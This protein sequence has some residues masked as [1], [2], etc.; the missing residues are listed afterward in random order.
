MQQP[1]AAITKLAVVVPHPVSRFRVLRFHGSHYRWADS[2]VKRIIEK[3]RL[4]L[5][6]FGAILRAGGAKVAKLQTFKVD[7]KLH[8]RAKIAAI[9]AGMKLEAWV[10][11]AIKAALGAGV[12]R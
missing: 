12:E 8:A 2:G 9:K 6:P 1:P 10:A 5:R 4:R 11:A 7:E 3:K